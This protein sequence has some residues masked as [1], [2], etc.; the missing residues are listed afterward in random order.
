MIPLLASSAENFGQ[1]E[2]ALLSAAAVLGMALIYGLILLTRRAHI[3]LDIELREA[4]DRLKE[5]RP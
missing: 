2:G 4:E 5:S 3:K 1:S